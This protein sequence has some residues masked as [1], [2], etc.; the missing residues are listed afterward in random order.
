MRTKSDGT[1]SE[2]RP[3]LAFRTEESG[4]KAASSVLIYLHLEPV[5]FTYGTDSLQVRK[6][7]GTAKNFRYNY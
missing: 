2:L 4:K 7:T 3:H 6:L 1:E 5:I